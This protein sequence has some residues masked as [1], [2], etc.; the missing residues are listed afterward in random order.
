LVEYQLKAEREKISKLEK[1][2]EKAKN[3]RLKWESKV[4]G[5]DAELIV[6][7]FQIFADFS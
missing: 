3:E 5:L 7:G 6:S 2:L 1:E 4:G